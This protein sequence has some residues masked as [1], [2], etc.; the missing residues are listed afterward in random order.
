MHLSVGLTITFVKCTV[1]TSELEKAKECY[2]WGLKIQKEQL[3]ANHV[4]ITASYDNL[5]TVYTK[6]G[7]LEKAK[8]YHEWALKIRKEQ[9][10]A[11]HVDVAACYYNLGI[12]ATSRFGDTFAH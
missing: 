5:G 3:R 6:T 8:E 10:G 9:L 7:V 12:E 2:Q 1:R 11:N 4:D